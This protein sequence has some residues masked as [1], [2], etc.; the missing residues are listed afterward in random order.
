MVENGA[1]KVTGAINSVTHLSVKLETLFAALLADLDM[2]TDGRAAVTE[3]LKTEDRLEATISEG[4]G[5]VL[6]LQLCK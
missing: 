5:K 1:G 4:W 2:V 3:L 6:R